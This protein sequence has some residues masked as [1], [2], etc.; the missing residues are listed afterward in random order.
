[1]NLGTVAPRPT[2][3][4][5]SVIGLQTTYRTSGGVMSALLRASDVTVSCGRQGALYYGGRLL[6]STLSR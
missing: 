4:V 6:L 1:M 2:R 5:N 3:G